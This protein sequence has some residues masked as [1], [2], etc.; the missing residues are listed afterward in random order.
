[1][2]DAKILVIEDDPDLG[3][4]I[5]Y[6]LQ[7]EGY[8]VE[9]AISGEQGLDLADHFSPD[10]VLL[11]IMLPG[12]DGFEVCRKL[13]SDKDKTGPQVIM[14]TART[15]END[16]VTGLEIGADDYITKPFSP[17][18]LG[19]RI[20]ARLRLA[21][22]ET[23][24][25]DR[26]TPVSYGRLQIDPRRHS[27]KLDDQSLTLTPTEFRILLL[28]AGKPGVVYS[29][30][31]IVDAVSGGEA[32]VTDRSVDVQIVGLRKKLGGCADYIET[33]RGFGYRCRESVGVR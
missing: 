6:N 30:Y 31:E 11:D 10:L 16:I 3:S 1:M 5:K 9:V 28:L 33:V 8:D 14:L 18:V 25:A 23:S 22:E 26:N 27:V 4:L 19:A 29:R 32:V 24:G 2:A 15:E 7:R 21:G 12:Q 20:R 17:R 13:K